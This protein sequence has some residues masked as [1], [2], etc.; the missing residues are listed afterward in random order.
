[1][2]D[3]K[4]LSEIYGKPKLTV[5]ENR[6]LFQYDNLDDVDQGKTILVDA[7]Q[8]T[9]EQIIDG[10]FVEPMPEQKQYDYLR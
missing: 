8:K 7:N 5:D 2:P 3:Y 10:T 6:A 1:M 4:L 9:I